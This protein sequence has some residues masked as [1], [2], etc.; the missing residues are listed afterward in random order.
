MFI[1]SVPYLFG[2]EQARQSGGR[3]DF[4]TQRLVTTETRLSCSPSDTRTAVFFSMA[5]GRLHS[6]FRGEQQI[7]LIP[8]KLPA[9]EL[10]NTAG[11]ELRFYR[12][13]I[14]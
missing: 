8:P 9:A 10:S 5:R 7:K 3:L 14:T 2:T 4:M 13:G 1:S 12:C 11:S 6:K